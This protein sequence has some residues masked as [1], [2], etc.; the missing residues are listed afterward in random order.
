MGYMKL[1]A[2]AD[3]E[4]IL[5]E[6]RAGHQAVSY[7]REDRKM[8]FLLML[9]IESLARCSSDNPWTV[10]AELE[11]LEAFARGEMFVAE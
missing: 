10:E 3:G 4:G 8:L 11:K 9:N 7:R 5:I 1:R 6:D 2:Y